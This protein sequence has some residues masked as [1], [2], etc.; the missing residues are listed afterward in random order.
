MDNLSVNEIALVAPKFEA[1][2][3]RI[4]YFPNLQTLIR[5]NCG[6]HNSSL[7]FAILLRLPPL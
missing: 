3:A 2:G 6:G 4:I 7:L 5:F 1:V